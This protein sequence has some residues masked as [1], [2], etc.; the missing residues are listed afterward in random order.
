MHLERQTTNV[1]TLELS[2]PT[3]GVVSLAQCLENNFAEESRKP[4]CDCCSSGSA[5]FSLTLSSLPRYITDCFKLVFFP[6]LTHT[7]SVYYSFPHLPNVRILFLV[8]KRYVA[9]HRKNADRIQVDWTVDMQCYV[10]AE[11]QQRQR[12]WQKPIVLRHD[13]RGNCRF[14]RTGSHRHRWLCLCL[15]TARGLACLF[16]CRRQASHRS[17]E[18]MPK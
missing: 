11:Q 18:P 16:G 9:P 13:R 15:Q 8:M 4:N 1:T 10:G 12:L 3:V 6:H 17:T 2:L 5:T 14:N 7:L